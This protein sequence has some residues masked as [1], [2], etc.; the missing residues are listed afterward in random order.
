MMKRI[1]AFAAAMFFAGDAQALGLTVSWGPGAACSGQSP[2]MRFSSVP[3][4]TTK[5]VLTMTDLDLP[6]YTHGGGSVDFT[7]KTSFAPG[8]LFGMFSSYRGPCP[9]PGTRHRYRWTVEAQD[10]AGKSLGRASATLP[11]SR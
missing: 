11:F 7:G 4:G 6:T 1:F 10:P 3:K 8:E 5:L 2:A 9:P